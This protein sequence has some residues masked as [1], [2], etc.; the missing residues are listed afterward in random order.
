MLKMLVGRWMQKSARKDI[1]MTFPYCTGRDI[2]YKFDKR[3]PFR[4]VK[5][6]DIARDI[7]KED[8]KTLR[9]Q[10]EDYIRITSNPK[11]D[12]Y[13][14]V[15]KNIK[16]ASG[17]GAKGLVHLA[18]PV[19]RDSI[20]LKMIPIKQYVVDHD[21]NVFR[22]YMPVA[23]VNSILRGF[24]AGEELGDIISRNSYLIEEERQLTHILIRSLQMILP[25]HLIVGDSNILTFKNQ[26]VLCEYATSKPDVIICSEK[27]AA[28]VNGTYVED[29]DE[30][31]NDTFG[32][33]I[34]AK[35][36]EFLLNQTIGN[37]IKVATDLTVI[38]LKQG[39]DI[40]KATVYGIAVNYYK[41]EGKILQ[42]QMNF[43]DKNCKI[44]YITQP[45]KLSFCINAICTVMTHY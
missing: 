11:G 28:V 43:D 29:E 14:L 12:V 16:T 5:P 6:K 18:S 39:K 7:A 25:S 31:H 26:E 4:M 3:E 32:L 21:V 37:M 17:G 41:M 2:L 9:F 22:E 36:N 10:G 20:L 38:A 23:T 8:R 44:Q 30:I 24:K 13:A 45:F 34:E 33:T 40:Q 42:L 15:H 19:H 27:S 1:S 35:R